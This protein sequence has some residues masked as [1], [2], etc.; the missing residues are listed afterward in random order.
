MGRRGSIGISGAVPGQFRHCGIRMALDKS[1]GIQGMQPVD[2]DQENMLNARVLQE[3]D[4]ETGGGR[5]RSGNCGQSEHQ[6]N[7]VSL[8]SHGSCL[9]VEKRPHSVVFFF[10]PCWRKKSFKGLNLK[11]CKERLHPTPPY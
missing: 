1:C 3:L 5:I 10:L 8:K 2:A 11:N 7:Q 9:A 6:A 4:V